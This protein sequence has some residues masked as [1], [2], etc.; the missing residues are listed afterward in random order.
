MNIL[1][2]KKIKSENLFAFLSMGLFTLWFLCFCYRPH[3]RESFLF[4]RSFED[5]FADYFNVL[6]YVCERDVYFNPVNGPGEKEYLPLAY[7]IFYPFSRFDNY[8]QMSLPD[9]WH[10]NWSLFSCCLFLTGNILLLLHSLQS[11]CKKLKVDDKISY[12]LLCSNIMLFTVERANIIL[13]AASFLNYFF[14]Y[15]DSKNNKERLFACIS[16]AISATLKIFPVVFIVFYLPRKQYKD[17]FTTIII[18]LLLAFLPFLFFKHGFGNIPQLIKNVTI[19]G[20]TGLFA[21]TYGC[22]FSHFIVRLYQ[23]LGIDSNLSIP[24]VKIVRYAVVGLAVLAFL[25]F[26][27]RHE[28]LKQWDEMTL[29]L[30]TLLFLPS[31]SR[32]YS[33]LFIFPLV[34]VYFATLADRKKITNVAL[35]FLFLIAFTPFELFESGINMYIHQRIIFFIGV[36][37]L[38]SRLN[39]ILK[40]LCRSKK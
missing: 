9:C 22:T 20:N 17:F 31:T 2:D 23:N 26:F 30:F 3:S 11:L 8:A 24:L 35:F 19:A 40:E 33:G 25:L 36:F 27:I 6:R 10:S 18:G 15:Y 29:I 34:I 13:L 5:L 16:L 4:F 12:I 14:V 37:V 32:R 39:V 7:M 21:A 1:A 28:T 38:F